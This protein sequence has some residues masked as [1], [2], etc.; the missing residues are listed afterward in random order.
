MKGTSTD[1]AK[2]DDAKDTSGG[3]HTDEIV[4]ESIEMLEK[5]GNNALNDEEDT[6]MKIKEEI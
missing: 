1:D 3:T 2:D 6:A 5:A 4:D